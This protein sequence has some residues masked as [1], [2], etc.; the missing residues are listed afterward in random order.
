M[1]YIFNVR[2]MLYGG[3]EIY[4]KKNN[5]LPCKKKKINKKKTV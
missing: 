3:L 5:L 2:K 1:K 4:I